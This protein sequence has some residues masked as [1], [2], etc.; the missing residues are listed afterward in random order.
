MRF[1]K[2]RPRV[3][4]QSPNRTLSFLLLLLQTKKSHL[5]KSESNPI[6]QAVADCVSAQTKKEK[7]CQELVVPKVGLQTIW[8]MLMTH[9]IIWWTHSSWFQSRVYG[10][11]NTCP[12]L[13]IVNPFLPISLTFASQFSGYIRQLVLVMSVDYI[14]LH[15][16]KP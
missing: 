1:C 13:S 2:R 7:A 9:A 3:I 12:A 10:W 6:L 4:F 11:E 15:V 14:A 8:A 5:K 16:V